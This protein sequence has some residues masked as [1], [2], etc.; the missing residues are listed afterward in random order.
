MDDADR[1]TKLENLARLKALA[2][3]AY[4][5]MYEA[6]SHRQADDFYRDAKDYYDDAIGLARHLGL[7]QE[8]ETMS[9]RLWHIK[10]VYR[11]QFCQ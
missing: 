11:H 4:D 6:H 1:E 3:K 7:I 8:A 2:E 10:Q 9:E 5:D